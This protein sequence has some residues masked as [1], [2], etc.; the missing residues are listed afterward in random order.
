[1]MQWQ[2]L[3]LG[4]SLGSLLGGLG[5]TVGQA[6]T[7][8]VPVRVVYRILAL[9]GDKTLS[10]YQYQPRNGTAEFLGREPAELAAWKITPTKEPSHDS[11]GRPIVVWCYDTR[12]HKSTRKP[13]VHFLYPDQ[14]QELVDGGYTDPTLGGLVNP[15]APRGYR[16][17][18]AEASRRW[19]SESRT[20]IDIQ[21]VRDEPGTTV[22]PAPQPAIP[23]TPAQPPVTQSGG[24]VGR[25][26]PAPG[27]SP[28]PDDSGTTHPT[29]VQPP[30]TQPGGPTGHPGPT[31]GVTVS[32][33]QRPSQRPLLPDQTPAGNP[34]KVPVTGHPGPSVPGMPAVA[35]SMVGGPRPLPAFGQSAGWAHRQPRPTDQ[36]VAP[37]RPARR[38]RAVRPAAKRPAL[39]DTWW[40]PLP[41]NTE[42]APHRTRHRLPQ[43]GSPVNWGMLGSGLVLLVGTLSGGYRWIRRSR[44]EKL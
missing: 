2:R 31:P 1:M 36:L 42:R 12:H 18:D 11:A 5:T 30:V 40:A 9:N 19:M 21:L 44:G 17:A 27:P 41:S 6:A 37:A 26:E 7:S 13:T 3:I 29:P 25:P 35:P 32:G 33:P 4:L 16:F 43:T 38:H 20:A 10:D 39:N 34:G 24:P 8:P 15:P 28:Q 14:R 22:A 23:G